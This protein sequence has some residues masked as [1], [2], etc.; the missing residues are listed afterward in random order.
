MNKQHRWI[1]FL[2]ETVQNNAFAFLDINKTHQHNQLKTSDIENLLS[3][4]FLN[5]MQVTLI[6][7]ARSHCHFVISLLFYWLG[8]H[9]IPSGS[10]KTKRN[11]KK[12]QPIRTFLNRLC[13]PRQV[14][15][16]APIKELL[17]IL[18]FLGTM[19][20]NLKRTLQTSIQN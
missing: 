8:L 2:S 16:T 3:V 11:F 5:T 7:L 6:N 10:W 20:S 4:V 12:E 19:P 9:T 18:L 13:V 15:L 14:Y 17:I 1:G